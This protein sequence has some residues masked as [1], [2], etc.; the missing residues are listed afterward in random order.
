MR[1][2]M[3]F[4]LHHPDAASALGPVAG[5]DDLDSAGADLL[6]RMLEMATAEPRL[7]TGEFVERFRHEEERDWVQQLAA[8]DPMPL[9]NEA[10]APKV[11]QDSLEQLVAR[12]RQSAQAAAIRRHSD[13]PAGA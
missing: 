8:A 13:P 11:L 3:T 9:E 10:D 6:R 4:I 12:H 5:L 7:R 2:V 1:S